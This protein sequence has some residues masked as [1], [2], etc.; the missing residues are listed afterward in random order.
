MIITNGKIKFMFQTTNQL[1]M[2]HGNIDGNTIDWLM[3]LIILKIFSQWE[4]LSSYIMENK[5]CLKLP[6]SYGN[7]IDFDGK[8]T[9]FHGIVL[10]GNRSYSGQSMG[11]LWLLYLS[12]GIST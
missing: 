8:W 5:K 2:V 3:V 9:S 4:G 7:T 10:D 1:C 6:T 11:Y 12:F